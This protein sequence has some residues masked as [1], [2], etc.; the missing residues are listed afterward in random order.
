MEQPFHLY[1]PEELEAMRQS[2]STHG[3][4]QRLIVRPYGEGLYQIIS[5][6]NR[7]TAA[8]MAGYTAV[9]C[10]IRALDDDEAE[11]QMLETNLNQR[12]SILLSEKAWA[13]RKRLEAMNRQGMR[14]DLT[15]VHDEQKLNSNPSRDVLA[16]S[17]PDSSAQIHRYIRLT[18]LIPEL[19]SHADQKDLALLAGEALSFLDTESQRA[20][21]R[22]FFEEHPQPINKRLAD[23]LR[24]AGEH[25]VL[26]EERI[27][28]LLGEANKPKMVRNVSV[29]PFRKYF[30]RNAPQSTIEKTIAAALKMYFDAGHNVIEK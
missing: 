27:L 13:Y 17:V 18:Y 4:I 12:K 23:R 14:T 3:V 11:M 1:G 16:Q 9:P 10:E 22:Y 19:L 29:K 21:Y 15:F 30:P 2:I 7:R 28:T 20:V 6:R 26:T 8:K 24:A 5:G 25:E